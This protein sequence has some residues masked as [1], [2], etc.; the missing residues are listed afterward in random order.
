MQIDLRGRIAI[1]TGA[2]RRIGIGAAVARTL[3]AAGADVF[4]TYFLPYDADQP[5]GSSPHEVEEQLAALR[6]LGVRAYGMEAN[7]LQPETPQRIFEAVE[8]LLGTAAILVNNATVSENG[9]IDEVDAAQ[10]DRHYAVN[11]RST[12]LLCKEFVRRWSGSGSRGGSRG[13]N[14][15]SNRGGYRP[16]GRIINMSSGQGVTPMPS[17]LAYATTKGAIEALTTSLAAGVANRGITV[18]AVDPGI[19]DTGWI[20]EELKAQWTAQAPFGRVG[21]PQDAANL[22]C[23]L[24]SEQGGWITGQVL[25]SRGGM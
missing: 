9:S 25:H 20:G 13:G 2:S 8:G 16:G 24:A 15:S 7:L 17:E 3:A 21:L 19:T 5:W 18:N 14:R 10:L 11:V 23:F 12:L 6:A 4:L 22:I 1:V